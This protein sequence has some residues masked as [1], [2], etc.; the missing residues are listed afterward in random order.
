MPVGVSHS[1]SIAQ[2][3]ATQDVLGVLSNAEQLFRADLDLLARRGSVSHVR[4]AA[5]SLAM[6]TAVRSSLGM[7]APQAPLLAARLLG[8][9]QITLQ[10][11]VIHLAADASASITVTREMLESIKEKYSDVS[12]VD[13]MRWPSMSESGAPLPPGPSQNHKKRIKVR[14]LRFESDDEGSDAEDEEHATKAYWSTVR[15]RYSAPIL[16]PVESLDSSD[17]DVLPEHWV[18][19]HMS[20]TEDKGAMFVSRQQ[21]RREPLVFCLPL[22]GR[23]ESEEDEQLGFDDAIDELDA[24]IRESDESTRAAAHVP[25]NNMEAR[26]AWWTARGELDK[27]LKALVENIEFCW[28][29]GFK[30]ILSRPSGASQQD[31]DDLRVRLESVFHRALHIRD[32]AQKDGVRLT[33]RLVECFGALAPKS[34]DEELEDVV[35][36]VLDLYQAAGVPVV[37]SEVDI[38]HTVIELRTVLEEHAARAPPIKAAHDD[39]H[40]FLV[41]DKNLQGLPWESIPMLR[42][43]SVSRVP[44][45]AFLRDRVELARRRQGASADACVDRAVVDP[46]KTFYILNP[47]G[48][49]KGTEARFTP[50]MRDMK[51]AA[52]WTGIVGRVPSEQE[53][54]AA[55]GR[56]E[57]VIY[58]G[59]GGGE[60]YAR[61]YKIRALPRCAATMLWGCSS[62]RLKP[63]GE[64]DRTGTPYHYMLAGCPTLVANLWDVTDRDIDKFTQ[65][66]FDKLALTPAGV[67]DWEKR[68]QKHSIVE[69]VAQA[70]EVCKLKYLTG[71]APVVYGIP[72]Y[73]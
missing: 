41:L 73:L 66:V 42:G 72:F 25:A 40:V 12:A 17:I 35:Y 9:H 39:T 34:R 28:L 63:Q 2:S 43:R 49:L 71:A 51:A 58:F 29:G 52:G 27:R 44:N 38:D 59:H 67:R 65:T 57:L 56:E 7:A 4:E 23:R 64:F 11:S 33:P 5:V 48:D 20:I 62:G 6:I 50:L 10:P 31:L 3:P 22:K 18:V 53:F 36:F 24:I 60:N 21:A 16:D 1:K 15:E 68:K 55:L 19:V 26:A 54:L 45:L 13:E 37:L 61:S 30:T 14:H 46:R 69:A 47:S 8:K 32:K 70:R